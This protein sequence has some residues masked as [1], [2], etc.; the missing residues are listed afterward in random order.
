[1]QEWLADIDDDDHSSHSSSHSSDTDGRK[2]NKKKKKKNRHQSCD[3]SNTSDSDCENGWDYS[4]T[5]KEFD[6][7]FEDKDPAELSLEAFA[8]FEREFEKAIMKLHKGKH[9]GKLGKNGE[10][11]YVYIEGDKKN[12]NNTKG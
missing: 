1:M 4:E 3:S 6:R 2:R 11:V 9:S 7:F 12:E 10:K 5:K 8:Q